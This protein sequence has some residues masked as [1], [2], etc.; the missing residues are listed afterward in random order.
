MY[1]GPST[2]EP[3]IASPPITRNVTKAVQFHASPHPIAEIRYSTARI[4][5]LSRRPHLSPGIPASIDPI[6]VPASALDTVTPS[7]S[8]VR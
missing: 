6:I 7:D 1:I 8:G 2:D 4:R 5:K 3:P